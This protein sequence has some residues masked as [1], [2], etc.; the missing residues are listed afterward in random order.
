MIVLIVPPKDQQGL[1]DD[2]DRYRNI[3]LGLTDLV[4]P[5]QHTEKSTDAAAYDRQCDQHAL[6]HTPSPRNRLEF[7]DP[8]DDKSHDIDQCQPDNNH[9]DI[10]TKS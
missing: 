2:Q 3:E 4:P 5:D 7:I 1:H 6:R 8:V 10:I 9:D